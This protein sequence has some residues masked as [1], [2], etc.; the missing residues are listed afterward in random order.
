MPKKSLRTAFSLVEISVVLA[1]ITALV[2]GVIKSQA[3][4]LKARLSTAQTITQNSSVKDIADLAIWYETTLESSFLF[5]EQ[6]DGGEIT[7]W[8]DN[9]SNAASKNNATQTSTSSKP[10][11]YEKV[12]ND[13]LPAVRFDGV[14]DFLTFDGSPLIGSSYTIFVVEQ[15]RAST[16]QMMFL[17]GVNDN[18]QLGY[19]SDTSITQAHSS[20]VFNDFTVAAYS[21][22]TPRIH[23]FWFNVAAGQKYWING[24]SG[25]D[26]TGVGFSSALT[27]YSG[28]AI[29]R[30]LTHYFN[31][32][33]AEIIIFTRALQTTERQ[34]VET[35]LGQKYNL[36]IS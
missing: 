23:T 31:G 17:G 25:A 24:G 6:V 21:S 28:A 13:S 33:I 26:D 30:Y 12:F 10:K 5:S 22:P 16:S 8:Q 27:S 20:G 1:I 32:D 3:M 19:R 29:G 34:V 35:Y 14:N 11:F 7:V 15:R 36:T 4:F 9:S 18:L 2:V